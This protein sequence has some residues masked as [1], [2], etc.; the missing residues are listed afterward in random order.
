[1]CT[2]IDGNILINLVAYAVVILPVLLQHF[3]SC[4]TQTEYFKEGG[5][6]FRVKCLSKLSVKIRWLSV[7]CSVLQE[8][9]GP[10]YFLQMLKKENGVKRQNTGFPN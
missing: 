8:Y 4:R 1:M 6:G 5:K 10:V 7:T 3:D 2:Q 9:S